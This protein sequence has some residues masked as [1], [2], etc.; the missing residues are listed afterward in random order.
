MIP[1]APARRLLREL[2]A[3]RPRLSVRSFTTPPPQQ[4]P[5]Q[6]EIA[7][8]SSSQSAAAAASAALQNLSHLTPAQI[9]ALLSNPPPPAPPHAHAHFQQHPPPR[10]NR[11]PPRAAASSPAPSG[12]SPSSRAP[13]LYSP[14]NCQ[15]PEEK[16]FYREEATRHAVREHPTLAAMV[17]SVSVSAD[18]KPASVRHSD[19]DHWEPYSDFSPWQRR[20]HL[21]AGSLDNPDGLGL[22]HLVFRHH[23]TGELVLAVVFG[24]GTSG[25]PSVVHGGML[26]TI[27][28]E[29]MGRLAALNFDAN[30]AVTAK[31]AMEFK[32]PATPGDVYLVRVNKVLPELQKD[33]PDAEDKTNRKLWIVGRMEGPEGEVVCE[34]KGL[35]VVPKSGDVKPLGKKF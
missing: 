9:T 26:S 18:G 2:S 32:E 16:R 7:R 1:R 30:T 8:Q 14:L 33:S 11:P 19:W 10:N 12:P 4:P 24:Q 20:Q 35:F 6:S 13:F 22:V 23:L 25:W 27:M 21:C 31:L 17:P 28:D 29:A 3:P 5:L 34:A 15:D